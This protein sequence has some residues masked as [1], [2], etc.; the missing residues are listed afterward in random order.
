MSAI[1]CLMK[2][3]YISMDRVPDWEDEM[4]SISHQWKRYLQPF[5]RREDVIGIVARLSRG[6]K[7]PLTD[8]SHLIELRDFLRQGPKDD[9][10]SR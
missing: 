3:I 7:K 6:Q 8:F 9:I 1:V 10:K 5:A 2:W 4:A